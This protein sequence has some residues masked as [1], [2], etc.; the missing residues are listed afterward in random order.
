M[1]RLLKPQTDS[2]STT[3]VSRMIL[4]RTYV[5]IPT[6]YDIPLGAP[7]PLGQHLCQ[8]D[9]TWYEYYEY[10]RIQYV[11]V[12][13]HALLCSCDLVIHV[14]PHIFDIRVTPTGSRKVLFN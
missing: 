1:D 12:S 11:Q 3:P 5:P 2:V 4:Y 14:N 7:L 13:Y 10:E 9:D 6:T 8:E